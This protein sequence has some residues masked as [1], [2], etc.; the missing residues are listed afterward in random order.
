MKA[1]IYIITFTLGVLFVGTSCEKHSAPITATLTFLE[2]QAG[3]T[4]I[5]GEALHMHGTVVGSGE[6]HG[7]SLTLTNLTTNQVVY[8]GSNA[9][10]Q[11]SYAFDEHWVNMEGA[12]SIMK[13]SLVVNLDH[14]GNTTTKSVEFVASN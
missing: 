3:D 14:E 1:A 12:T 10:H 6:L 8:S 4:V 13:L 11:S 2:P 5:A 9:T 7:Y